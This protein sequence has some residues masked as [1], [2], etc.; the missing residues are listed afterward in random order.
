MLNSITP[1]ILIHI[2]FAASFFGQAVSVVA[3]YRR[4]DDNNYICRMIKHMLVASMGLSAFYFVAI[5][6]INWWMAIVCHS[7]ALIFYNVVIYHFFVFTELY[8]HNQMYNAKKIYGVG[9]FILLDSISLVVNIFTRHVVT[10]EEY[11][12]DGHRLFV[13]QPTY[14]HWLHYLIAILTVLY[15]L[16]VLFITA[17]KAPYSYKRRY[18]SVAIGVACVV[19]VNVIFHRTGIELDLSGVVLPF[20]VIIIFYFSLF[21]SPK[22][23][24]SATKTMIIDEMND[25]FVILDYNR[26]YRDSNKA[27]DD[28]LGLR[29]GD[30]ELILENWIKSHDIDLTQSEVLEFEDNKLPGSPIL[31]ISC[32][33]YYE[34]KTPDHLTATY[35]RIHDRTEEI[36]RR[37]EETY[38]SMHDN[39]TGL[40]NKDAF[41]AE[42]QKYLSKL[43][44]E[45]YYI[46]CTNIENFKLYNNLFGVADGDKLLKNVGEAL[47]ACIKD[48]A[49]IGRMEA[50]RFC[51]L[52][53]KE[54][55][56]ETDFQR[57]YSVA[58]RLSDR[59]HYSVNA[60]VG[61][62][63]VL[64]TAES[65]TTLYNRALLAAQTIKGMS[66]RFVAFYDQSITEEIIEEQEKI[67]ELSDALKNEEFEFFL[68]PQVT[69][70]GE[71]KGGEALVR[72]NHPSKGI[73]S[74]FFFIDIM[75]RHGMIANLDLLVWTKVCRK[76]EEW[77]KKGITD[78]YISVNI[79]TKD[80]YYMDVYKTFNDLVAE[81]DLDRS[82]LKL[83]ITESAIMNNEE[84]Q[85]ALIEDLRKSGFTVEMDDFGSGY[86][87]LNMLNK[88]NVDILKLDMG[89]LQRNADVER[90]Q[91]I[92]T[93]IQRLA[94]SL[95][96]IT[97]AEGVETQE[98]ADFLN[99]V[100]VDL[101][102]GYLYSPPISVAEYEEKYIKR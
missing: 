28:L 95:D 57:V 30:P 8:T 40:Y 60:Y 55:F 101:Q 93:A 11:L 80:F 94:K 4:Y 62:T 26:H 31:Q 39:L 99:S 44:D 102:Q 38:A 90:S 7:I 84:E 17:Y 36:R 97:I 1:L 79:S 67:D 82:K 20:A 52:M 37:E 69:S 91:K 85:L 43:T 74:P 92:L 78:Q 9:L 23:F 16:S 58:L 33:Q 6:A 64:D 96:M 89:F 75:E 77:K 87:S 59:L 19:I 98:Q 15:S 13:Y 53:P 68:Q 51:V 10:V 35:I 48:A 50:D 46:V 70:D 32:H 18:Q 3:L 54:S 21:H 12:L 41:I 2:L 22:Q 65:V 61:V 73:V 29:R 86:S 45:S 24:L 47:E 72:W 42:A 27:A 81:H 71:V 88:M 49:V 66:D 34:E 83:E 56:V 5:H 76:L 63:E 25:A 100:G 14:L